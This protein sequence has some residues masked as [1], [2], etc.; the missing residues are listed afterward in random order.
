MEARKPRSAVASKARPYKR[1]SRTRSTKTINCL[2][3]TACFASPYRAAGNLKFSDR[4][5]EHL[6]GL[7]GRELQRGGLPPP[8]IFIR[9]FRNRG[10]RYEMAHE[11]TREFAS[12][13][14]P[15]PRGASWFLAGVGGRRRGGLWLPRGRLLSHY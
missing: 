3:R 5:S 9:F 13:V 7:K 1:W 2:G 11:N 12:E 4:W 14:C 6:Q 15:L 8:L 10:G